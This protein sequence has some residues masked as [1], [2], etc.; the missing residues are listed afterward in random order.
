MTISVIVPVYNSQKTISQCLKSLLSQTL[1]PK[2]IIIIDDGSTDN[3]VKQIKSIQKKN[4]LIKLLQQSHQGPAI[5]R[6][7]SAQKAQGNILVFVDADMEF[8]KGFLKKLTTPIIANKAK[9]T[10]SA[11]E[12]V[13]NWDNLWAR[14][15]NYNQNRRSAKMIGE[16]QGQRK[17]F[18]A[19]L[20]S[21]FDRV[22]G[23]DPTGYT[24]DWTLV[25]K[26]G[27]QPAVTQA[28]FFHYSPSTLLEVFHQ[29]RW[30]GKRQ[31]KLGKL[32]S[33][34][35]IFRA[36]AAFSVVIAIIKAIRF[37]TPAFLIFK[38]VYDLGILVGAL[39]SL[40]GKRY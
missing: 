4:K 15:W 32:G 33:L 2:E 5:A 1:K 29:A 39:E 34:I 24:D 40:T 9:G 12:W 22:N 3:T 13:K 10:W 17:V 18:R 11:N 27:Y 20:K 37:I 14:C 31:Y 19:I 26:L 38:L 7:L 30:I 8:D 21:E 16:S 6:N 36:N 35:A 28:K 25:N 23:F